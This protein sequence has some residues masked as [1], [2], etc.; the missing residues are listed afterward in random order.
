MYQ[1]LINNVWITVNIITY[2]L[3]NYPTRYITNS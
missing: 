2:Y 1:I 3:S